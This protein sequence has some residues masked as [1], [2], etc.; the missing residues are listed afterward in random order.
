MKKTT[1]QL[2]TTGH[3]PRTTLF[4]SL[5]AAYCLLITCNSFAWTNYVSA[6][7]S[8]TAPYDTWA[9]AANKIQN[10]VNYAVE[11][12]VVLVADGNY[13]VSSQ[14]MIVTNSILLKSANGA[15]NVSIDGNSTKHP[16]YLRGDSVIDGFSIINGKFSN[17]GGIFVHQNGGTILNCIF[18]NNFAGSDGG[19]IRARGTLVSNCY[20]YANGAPNGGGVFMRYGS[21]IIDCFFESNFATNGGAVHCYE[22]NAGGISD[23]IISNNNANFGGGISVG[24]GSSAAITNTVVEYNSASFYGGGIAVDG[25]ELSVAQNCHIRDNVAAN[26]GGGIYANNAD[27]SITGTNT[28]L[29]IFYFWSGANWC[30]NG[31]GGGMYAIDSD[32]V[33]SGEQCYAGYNYSVRDGAAFYITNS[34]LSLLDGVQILAG[35]G[36]RSGGGIFAMDSEIVMNDSEILFCSATNGGG[37]FAMSSTGTFNNS[38]IAYNAANDGAGGGIYVASTGSYIFT[39]SVIANNSAYF[40]GGIVADSTVGS[41]ILNNTDVITNRARGAG[42]MAGGI[43]WYSADT[44]EATN[45]CRISNNLS[46]NMVGGAYIQSLGEFLFHDTEISYNIASNHVGGIAVVNMG[47]IECTDCSINNNVADANSNGVGLVGALYIINASVDLISLNGTST[48]TN[49]SAT[50]GGAVYLQ[51]AGQLSAY[52]D[53]LFANNRASQSGGAIYATNL[54][55]VSLMPTNGFSPRFVDN[56]ANNSGGGAAIYA[57]SEFT[58]AN[59]RFENNISSNLGGAFYLFN[60]STVTVYGVFSGSNTVP[61]CAFIGNAAK[62]GGVLYEQFS[63]VLNIS[64]SLFVSN[65]AFAATGHGG[66]I[67]AHNGS[68]VNIVN[69]IAAH[70]NAVNGGGFSI[71]AGSFLQMKQCTITGNGGEGIIGLG[72]LAITNSIIW[73]NSGIE[74][75]A[76]QVVDYCDIGGGYATG[77]GNIAVPPLFVDPNALNFQLAFGSPCINTGTAVNVSHDCIGNPRPTGDGYDLGAYE[78]IPEGGGVLLFGIFIL[79][80]KKIKLKLSM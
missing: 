20:F 10:A 67:R 62:H 65:S 45:G 56:F 41:F 49:N 77:N 51:T 59:P 3:G 19:A 13:T 5:L 16:I 32:I 79:F 42:A 4:F 7:G 18:T 64:D 11:G 80:F 73:N 28:Y 74:V 70:N 75:P 78:F 24:N 21:S 34:S 1:L 36:S 22:S 44:L 23:C 43:Y 37:I 63:S 71:A 31:D 40:A 58:A 46:D 29:G 9:K 52:G 12:N 39:D 38:M 33:L 27:V 66:A 26:G 25:G 54:C 69:S 14:I 60:A 35:W 15:A 48:V 53:V 50:D 61:P 2:R 55:T 47:R 68:F 6:A 17:G 57:K 72:T 30:S 8:D 76:G